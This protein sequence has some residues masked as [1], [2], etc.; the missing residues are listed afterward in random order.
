[1][2]EDWG[3]LHVALADGMVHVR[4]R[5]HPQAGCYDVVEAEPGVF[6]V[7]RLGEDARTYSVLFD[8]GKGLARCSCP[9]FARRLAPA[10]EACKHIEAVAARAA[11]G[12]RPAWATDTPAKA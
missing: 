12:G 3:I 2:I 6:R 11:G 1:V 4:L 8:Q 10:M 7:T 9:H 5:G